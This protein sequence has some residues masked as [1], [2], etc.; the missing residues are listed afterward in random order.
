M[1]PQRFEHLLTLIQSLI[2]KKTTNFREPI[3]PGEQLSIILRFLASG[4]SQQ[5][6]SFSFRIGKSTVSGI[7]RDTCV[8]ICNT[9]ALT[10][11]CA[12]RTEED[13]L[14]IPRD[15]E[16]LW[17]LPHV[18]VALDGKHIRC[19]R[20]GGTGTLCHNYKGLFDFFSYL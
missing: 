16:E 1:F 19:V 5:S 18:I 7:I 14:K 12:P 6:L 8:A 10:Y 17:N 15:F 20:P 11:L 3:S 13:W 4:E 9:L 2:T